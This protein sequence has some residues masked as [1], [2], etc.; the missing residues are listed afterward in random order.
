MKII[1]NTLRHFS[2][3]QIIVNSQTSC[4]FFWY[5]FW[6]LSLF[7]G[8]YSE[9]MSLFQLKMKIF[10]KFLFFLSIFLKRTKNN[11]FI[12]NWIQLFIISCLIFAHH[13]KIKNFYARKT[14]FFLFELNSILFVVNF[15]ENEKENRWPV[16]SEN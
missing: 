8:N 5:T 16:L 1:L 7:I 9:N 10:N 12:E 13:F 2:F 14:I 3:I 6:I 4:H 11:S 15:E